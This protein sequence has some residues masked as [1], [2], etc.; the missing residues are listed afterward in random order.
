MEPIQIHV[1][2]ELILSQA[3]KDFF[4]SVVLNHTATSAAPAAPA[5]APVA[6]PAPAPAAPAPATAPATAAPAD[7]TIEDVR[8]VLASKVANHRAEIKAKLEELGAPS[9]TKL[10]PEKY[11]EMLN[12]LNTLD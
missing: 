4:S 6:A 11:P 8:K 1:S 9:V 3:V 10:D 5:A 7:V 12:F 2:V